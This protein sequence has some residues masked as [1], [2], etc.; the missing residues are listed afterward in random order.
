MR[1]G[2]GVVN[3]KLEIR[4][5]KLEWRSGRIT[6]LSEPLIL[7]DYSDWADY[8]LNLEVRN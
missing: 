8:F 2:G 5:Q 1:R 4:S 6:H 3:I 7:I